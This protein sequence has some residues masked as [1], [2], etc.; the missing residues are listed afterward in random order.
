MAIAEARR[1]PAHIYRTPS[2]NRFKVG[3]VKELKFLHH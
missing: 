2:E 1:R 3:E